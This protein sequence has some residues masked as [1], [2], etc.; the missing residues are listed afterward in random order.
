MPNRVT[1][2]MITVFQKYP[3][4]PPSVHASRKLMGLNELNSANGSAVMSSGSLT[5][6]ETIRSSG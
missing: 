2:V 5:A 4:K 1:A 3:P 6:V